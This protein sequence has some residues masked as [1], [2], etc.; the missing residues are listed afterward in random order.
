MANPRFKFTPSRRDMRRA[1][2]KTEISSVSFCP[3]CKQPKIS[4]RI[5]P[6]CGFYNGEF[7]YLK[8]K[9]KKEKK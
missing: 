9:K 8:V 7:V 3:N 5:C 6:S 2:W 4:H 1:H